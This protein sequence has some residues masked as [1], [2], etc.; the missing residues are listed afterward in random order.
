[1]IN[2]NAVHQHKKARKPKQATGL[3]QFTDSLIPKKPVDINKA[4]LCNLHTKQDI[5]VGGL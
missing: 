4:A 5:A 2:I 1:M 3:L